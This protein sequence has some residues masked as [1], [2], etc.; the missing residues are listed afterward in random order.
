MSLE[1]LQECK[2]KGILGKSVGGKNAKVL[3]YEVKCIK[4]LSDVMSQKPKY[5]KNFERNSHWRKLSMIM[6]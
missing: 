6:V 3:S 4:E 2:F 1:F 5:C